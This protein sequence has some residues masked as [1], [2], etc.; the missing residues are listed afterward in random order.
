M[1]SCALAAGMVPWGLWQPAYHRAL[2]GTSQ[3]VPGSKK[4]KVSFMPS[5]PH[6]RVGPADLA[7]TFYLSQCFSVAPFW[8]GHYT[9]N[10]G[11]PL[12]YR[13]GG[14]SDRGDPG[15]STCNMAYICTVACRG[16]LARAILALTLEDNPVLQRG[17]PSPGGLEPNE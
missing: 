8:M 17:H 7:R 12:K 6:R 13:M 15:Y 3:A 14:H 16:C 11:R 2:R 1:S 4:N 5:H 9:P 10:K